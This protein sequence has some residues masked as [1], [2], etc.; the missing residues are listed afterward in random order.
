MEHVVGNMAA[1]SNILRSTAKKFFQPNSLVLKNVLN[2]GQIRC[3]SEHRTMNIE[4]SRWQWHKTKDWLHFYIMVGAIPIGLVIFYANVFIGPATL[5]EIPE[6]Y[7]PKHWEYHRHPIKRFMSRYVFGNP[8]EEYER[9]L[10]ALWEENECRKVREL[11]SKVDN[12]I[13]KRED[14]QAFYY[15]PFFGAKY[16]YKMHDEMENAKH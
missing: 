2:T 16:L 9:Y 10:H 3:M 6:G 7:V 13:A 11:E 8:Q 5:E 4:P 14:Y 12:L 15:T 1:W